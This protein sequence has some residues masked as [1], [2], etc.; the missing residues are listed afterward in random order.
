M[1]HPRIGCAAPPSGAHASG[2][3]VG[4][5]TDTHEATRAHRWQV[6][7]APADYTAQMLDAIVGIEIEVTRLRAMWKVSQTRSASERAGV[8]AGPDSLAGE[9]ALAMSNLVRGVG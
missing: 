7:D 9:Q 1:H 5:L 6:D 3:P 4:R 8:A 2:V